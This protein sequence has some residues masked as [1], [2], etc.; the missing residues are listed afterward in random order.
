MENIGL[1]LTPAV[2]A[3]LIGL[4]YR[5]TRTTCLSLS[6]LCPWVSH[7]TLGRLLGSALS[8]SG[9]L[10]EVFACRLIEEAGYLVIDDTAWQRWAKRAE[11]VSPV[12]CG[13]L[14]KVLLGM[15]VVLLIWTDGKWKVPIG[16][17]LWQKGGASKVELAKE[18]LSFAA[19]RGLKPKYVVFDSWYA[20]SSILNLLCELRWSYVAQIKSNRKMGGCPVRRL[21]PQRYGQGVGRLTRVNHQVRVIKDGRRYWASNNLDLT[22][23]Q[24]K[25]HYRMRQ[26]IEETFR[27]LKQEFGWGAS[28]MRKAKAQIAHLHLGLI[29]L[30]LTQHAAYSQEQTIYAFKREL[31]RQPIPTH[32][33]LFNDFLEA[34]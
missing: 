30:C 13:T 22:R 14:G 7:D 24:M 26:Q 31:F 29:A 32:L 33:P 11:A 2:Q 1:L 27:L 34:A 9:R 3:Y 8:W 10:W 15:Q 19:S 21:W 20:A 18:L 23:A 6:A 25:Q 12:W 17:R 28:R 4:I 16:M 5:N